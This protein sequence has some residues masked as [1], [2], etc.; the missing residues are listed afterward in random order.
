MVSLKKIFS[1]E[2]LSI[3]DLSYLCELLKTKL[4]LN[5]CFILLENRK[6]SRIF[7]QIRSRLDQGEMI[8]TIIRDYLPKKI[9]AYV[10]AL[11]STLSLSSALD[12]SLN[13]YRKQEESQ[14]SLLNNLA[15]PLILLFISMTALYLFDLYGVDAIFNMVSSFNSDLELYGDLRV[16]FRIMVN[17][18][19]YLILLLF[20]LGIIFTQP[21]RIVLLYIFMSKHFPNSLLNI[22]YSEEF[23]SLL[24]ITARNGYKTKEALGILKNMRSKPVVS[25]LAFHLDE[26]LMEGETLK[27]AVKRNYYDSSLSRFIKIA[28]YTGNFIGVIDSYTTL[29]RERIRSRLKACTLIIQII[30]YIFI[31]AVIIFIY[32]ILF[33]P[34][35]AISFY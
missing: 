30:T 8:E 2:T 17:I 10:A 6:N 26:A 12:L 35:Q 25:F 3:E 14:H 5:E 1:E 22:Y 27:E 18:F 13:F 7:K 16:L 24:L 29:S 28:N 9:K 31:G 33:M 15:Y 11:L 32:Q 21:K 34:M 4:S 20:L 23:M 19:Y